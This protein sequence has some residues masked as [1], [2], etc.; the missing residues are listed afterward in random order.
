[1]SAKNVSSDRLVKMA[2][3][4]LHNRNSST[5]QKSLAGSVLSQ[6]DSEKITSGAMASKAGKALESDKYN[7]VTKT[8]AGSV[9]TQTKGR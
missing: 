6:A 1:M 2:I 5:I 8:L 4:I 9:L 3:D 7:Q